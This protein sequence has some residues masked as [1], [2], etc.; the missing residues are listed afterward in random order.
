MDAILA[1]VQPSSPATPSLS[2][3][4]ARLVHDLG[5]FLK[6]LVGCG[7]SGF[8]QA[9]ADLGLPLSQVRALHALSRDPGGLS[10]GE[11]AE[12]TGLSMP[13]ASRTV[14]SLVQRGLATRAESPA[15]RRVKTVRATADARDLVARLL[16]LRLAGLEELVRS[17]TAAERRT[18][19]EA[20]EPIVA[21]EEVAALCG[22]AVEH[23][24]A[25]TAESG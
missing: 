13:T 20:L 6:F 18:L 12:H 1:S 11:L 8:F 9:V 4:D 10:L 23:G 17:L 24:P 25:D 14:D 21:R 5:G 3:R 16:D 19:A 2:G 15:D 22:D 7:Q